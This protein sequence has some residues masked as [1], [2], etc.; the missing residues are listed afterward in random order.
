[1]RHLI[2]LTT[3]LLLLATNRPAAAMSANAADSEAGR[4]SA[5]TE[6]VS[7]SE[8]PNSTTD[9]SEGL[10]PAASEHPEGTKVTQARSPAATVAIVVNPIALLFNMFNVD[11]GF[12]VADKTSAN[13]GFNYWSF[14][15]LGVKNTAWG[16][17]VGAQYFF[18]R[19]RF[20]GAFVY[21]ALEYASSRV[22]V[23]NVEITGSLFG[24][25]AI[26]GYQWNW[27]PFT[28]RVGGGG[29][30]YFGTIA[31][32]GLRSDLE[33]FEF[34]FDGSLGLAF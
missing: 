24:P 25:S 14:E 19:D 26:V 31:G 18:Y 5:E 2:I 23:G 29:R 9:T 8:T 6:T 16:L 3:G 12:A 33:G 34:K 28:L 17:G 30:Y 4:A 22:S 21:P 15:V 11:V 1:M 20:E 27:H 13:I 10:E 7:S 32:Q